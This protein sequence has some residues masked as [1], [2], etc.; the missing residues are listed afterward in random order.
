[1]SSLGVVPNG[2]S[3]SQTDPLWDWPVLLHGPAHLG[4]DL[5]RLV[6][7]PR[8]EGGRRAERGSEDVLCEFTGL[9]S[10]L[11]CLNDAE[12]QCDIMARYVLKRN[13]KRALGNAAPNG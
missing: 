11:P 1:M 9:D 13:A 8:E 7:R 10:A 4:L 2:V 6:R 5:E 12:G 3:G